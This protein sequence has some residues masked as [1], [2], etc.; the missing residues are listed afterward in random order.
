MSSIPEKP[1]AQNENMIPSQ[2]TAA[3]VQRIA[4]EAIDAH[5]DK[6]QTAFL[7]K[8][9]KLIDTSLTGY[10]RESGITRAVN[11]AIDQRIG[12]MEKTLGII[13]ETL[14]TKLAAIS[15]DAH[16]AKEMAE[17]AKQLAQQ[18][19][20]TADEANRKAQR[21]ID[22][23]IGEPPEPG[24]VSRPSILQIYSQNIVALNKTV[25]E[26]MEKVTA[27]HE[28]TYKNFLDLISDLKNQQND[29]ERRLKPVERVM[30]GVALIANAVKKSGRFGV[31]MVS[32]NP[33]LF[34]I[35]GYVIT[36]I[37]S[38]I[39]GIEINHP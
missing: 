8:V 38:A 2:L 24:A 28:A 15:E 13:S 1:N 39:V 9:Q 16:E 21:V 3:D 35:I 11:V 20:E 14:D 6:W 22:D 26:H 23:V 7:E 5:L 25:D 12:A 31:Q 34:R 33:T 37:V 29:F 30:N 18:G 32:E 17:M 36:V 10:A 27:M 4:G 19:K